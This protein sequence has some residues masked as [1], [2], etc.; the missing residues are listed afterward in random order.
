[1]AATACSAFLQTHVSRLA[2]PAGPA[3]RVLHGTKIG[4][5]IVDGEPRRGT[6]SATYPVVY[7]RSGERAALT[8]IDTPAL[9]L[10]SYSRRIL[11]TVQIVRTIEHPG[12][13]DMFDAG[14]VADGRPYL[15]TEHL[16]GLSLAEQVRDGANLDPDVALTILRAICAPLIEAH[17]VGV[18]H[19]TLDLER[20]F[21]VEGDAR[22]V[23]LLDWGIER[24]VMDEARRAGLEPPACTRC[25]APEEV[26]GLVSPQTDVYALGVIAHQLLLGCVP[27]EPCAEEPRIA[28]PRRLWPTMPSSLESLMCDLLACDPRSRPTIRVAAERLAAVQRELAAPEQRTFFVLESEP[29]PEPPRG[30]PR[31]G[32]VTCMFATVLAATTIVFALRS[33]E[34]VAA[35]ASNTTS[36][37]SP[38]PV[39]TTTVGTAAPPAAA[40]APPRPAAAVRPPPQA[41]ADAPP[42]ARSAPPAVATVSRADA[43]PVPA[44]QRRAPAPSRTATPSPSRPPAPRASTPPSAGEDERTAL[45]TQYQRVGHQLIQLRNRRGAAETAELW[46]QFRALEI[47]RALATPETRRKATAVLG[48][49]RE[50]IERNKGVTLTEACLK[51]PLGDACR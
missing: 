42:A 12:A 8:V 1:M 13:V 21:L 49:L 10:G 45:L 43:P 18:V 47:E 17:A 40:T 39:V 22:F 29:E 27:F 19:G 16:E 25:T 24:A 30:P 41:T 44:R 51:N 37:Q 31:W 26:F 38:G 50:K 32:L 5:W 46:R 11:S 7:E 34:P 20:V 36:Q 4:A 3:L 48:E 33:Q 35:S 28:N 14:L 9:A 6:A 23:K 15:V 2:M